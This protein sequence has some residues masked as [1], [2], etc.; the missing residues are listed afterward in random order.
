[1]TEIEVWESGSGNLVEVIFILNLVGRRVIL[2]PC[3]FLIF[4]V[5]RYWAKL[6][7]GYF[8]FPA[9]GQS[10]IK[11]NCHN[12]RT[13]NDID[14]KLGPVSEFD[15]RTQQRQKKKKKKEL[16]GNCHFFDLCSIWSNPDAGFRTHNLQYLHFH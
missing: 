11:E 6:R 5:S 14:I 9:S 7:R 12:S 1:M 3:W 15:K 13:S 10:L 2:L 16:C 4:S 8:L